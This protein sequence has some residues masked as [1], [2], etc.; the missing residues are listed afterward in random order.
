MKDY[1]KPVAIMAAVS[2]IVGLLMSAINNITAPLIKANEEA[3]KNRTYFAALPD[4]GSF[5]R[6]LLCHSFQRGSFCISAFTVSL[7][8]THHQGQSSGNSLPLSRMPEALPNWNA[9][10]KE[11]LQCRK[12]AMAKDM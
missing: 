3:E 9:G 7:S 10:S 11:S 2:F 12:L 1:I 4:A 6:V 8:G 5:Y